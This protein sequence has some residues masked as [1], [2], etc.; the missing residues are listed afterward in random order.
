MQKILARRIPLLLFSLLLTLGC[1]TDGDDQG[2]INPTPPDDPAPDV[3]GSIL[4]SAEEIEVISV[5]EMAL[6]TALLRSQPTQGPLEARAY[7]ITYQTLN[8]ENEPIEASGLVLL[9][10][11]D[12]PFPVI[13]Y[14]HGTLFDPSLAPSFYSNQWSTKPAITALAGS[15]YVLVV[16]DYLGYGASIDYPHPYSHKETLA[17]ASYDMLQAA[18]EFLSDDITVDF[19]Q[20]FLTG[21]SE[22]GYATMALHQY[23]EENTNRLIVMSAPASGSYHI[24]EFAQQVISSTED[25]RFIYTYLWVLDSY[26]RIYAIDRDWEAMVSAADAQELNAATP[27]EYNRIPLSTDPQ[28]LFLPDF[29]NGITNRTDTPFIDA[30][31]DND[32]F[33]WSPEAPITL[34]YGTEDDFVFPFNSQDAAQA[35]EQNGGNITEVAYP[36]LD[37]FS[38]FPEYA[39]DVFALFESLR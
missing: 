39:Q 33:D 19:E 15:G 21:Y 35:I 29:S 6:F 30:L 28:Q 11:G 23:I 9:P 25:L 22:G 31:A 32:V 27:F 16:P 17:R 12:G 36:G 38:T 8:A 10:I 37:H 3:S 13:S 7:R 2:S 18:E 1:S 4:E 14:Q 26:N 5:A 20:L 34:Y 24:S